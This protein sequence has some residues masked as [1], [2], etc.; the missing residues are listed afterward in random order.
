MVN[1]CSGDQAQLVVISKSF[2]LWR[3][4]TNGVQEGSLMG[5]VLLTTS[6]NDLKKTVEC[7]LIR[8]DVASSQQ[9]HLMQ[10][11]QGTQD[12]LEEEGK[13]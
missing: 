12:S 9:D 6:I 7:S 13:H 4:V 1:N 8:C 5:L 11:C 3:L 10:G 2:S